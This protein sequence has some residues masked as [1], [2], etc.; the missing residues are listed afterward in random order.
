[1]ARWEFLGNLMPYEQAGFKIEISYIY[2]LS[3]I[4]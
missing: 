3:L 2:L 4:Q 1:M